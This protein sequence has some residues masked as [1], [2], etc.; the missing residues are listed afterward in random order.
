[1]KFTKFEKRLLKITLCGAVIGLIG[2]VS[3]F[4]SVV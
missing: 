3:V 2:A 4:M 1:M